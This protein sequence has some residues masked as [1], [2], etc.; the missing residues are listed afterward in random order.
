M[1]HVLLAGLVS[2][3]ILAGQPSPGAGTI[4]GHV[5]NSLTSVPVRKA[6]V[7][8]TA[9]QIGLTAETDSEGK[10]QFTGLPPGAYQLSASRS[11]FLE[12]PVR[13]PIALGPEA[14]VTDAE[15]RLPPQGVITGRILDLDGDPADA[16]RVLAFRQVYRNGRQ[17]WD[18]LNI[19]S[20]T[21]ST[22]E[23]RFADL[24]PGRY[25]VQAHN[26]RPGVD[27]RY[28]KT[29]EPRE[30]YIPVYYP[31]APWE[32]SALPVDVGAGADVRGIDIQLVKQARPPSVHVRGKV[33]G[34]QPGS[35]ISVTLVS[36]DGLS[37]GGNAMARP[38]DYN[39][40]LSVSLGQYRMIANVYSGG[41]EA[42]A[43]GSVTVPGD[44]NDM[45]V[46]MTPAPRLTGRLS[47]AESKRQLNLRDV[48][49][50][51][52]PQF[53]Y[54]GN[55][56]EAVSDAA[57]NLTFASPVRPGRYT[58]AVNVRSIPDGYFVQKVNLGGEEVAMNDVEI[59]AS[60]QLEIVLGNT[61]GKI[62]GLATDADGRL[63]S[64]S[65]VTLIP[66]EGKSPPQSQPVGDDGAFQFTALAPG[67]YKIFAWELLDDALW[68]DPEY[69]RKYDDRAKEVTI[70]PRE[71][72]DVQV[73]MITTE[74][75]KC[76]RPVLAVLKDQATWSLARRSY[77]K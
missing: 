15:I 65:N 29:G 39:F 62:T 47:V 66:L 76:K 58:I 77:R 5:F 43:T 32:Q 54:P 61:A 46:T 48:R 20:L 10:F 70:A 25:L 51:L 64:R 11:G 35:E 41:E 75:M 27:N 67:K 57:G 8:L 34:A 60:A 45:V 30:V 14:H 22:G 19:V 63:F 1:T 40:D 53:I 59:H 26:F 17:Q 42:Y 33:I 73:Q 55:P 56:P 12:R 9:P 6:T 37:Y 16:V 49:V 3:C 68:Q 21:N 74:E 50:T 52:V 31:N 72:A 23:Y 7:R 36:L 18:R 44:V 4:E 38:P 13:R 28:G 24:K 2:V 69:C 71:T